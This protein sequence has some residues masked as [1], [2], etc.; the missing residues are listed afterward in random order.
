MRW[1]VLGHNCKHA[2]AA[3]YEIPAISAIVYENLEAARTLRGQF[4]YRH[5]VAQEGVFRG[6]R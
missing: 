6:V 4:G 1:V 3:A 5:D 2:G